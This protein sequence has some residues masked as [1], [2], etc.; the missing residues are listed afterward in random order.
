MKKNRNNE[1]ETKK[2][3]TIVIATLALFVIS[4]SV[5]F[6]VNNE[7]GKTNKEIVQSSTEDAPADSYAQEIDRQDTG[8]QDVGDQDTDDQ[9]TGK[10]DAGEQDA[11]IE[12]NWRI[13]KDWG[14]FSKERDLPYVDAEGLEFIRQAYEK[15]DFEGQFMQGDLDSYEEYKE[16]YFKLINNDVP[17]Q[18]METGEETYLKDFKDIAESLEIY[19]DMDYSQMLLRC[20]YFFFDMDGDQFP[21]L[22]IRNEYDHNAVYIFKYNTE[23]EKCALWY[24][25]GNDYY[26]I[27]G[28]KKVAW[29]WDGGRYIAF[30]QLNADGKTECETFGLFTCFNSEESLYM[31]M[32]PIYSEGESIDISD[33]LKEQGVYSQSEEQWYFRVTEAQYEE[34]MAPFWE[35]YYKAEKE[36]E[37]VT[38]TYEE[39]FGSLER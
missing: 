11:N 5:V 23:T 38:Y 20:D 29:L 4:V 36:S 24:V 8:E 33:W 19:K 32:L 13:Y 30:Y 21:E 25:L 10:Q 1:N 26:E 31:V 3:L 22:G 17:I 39:L 27:F 34:L 16:F 35:A 9:D 15:V 2:L 14:Y 37:K 18:N 7:P 12:G 28:S 6:V